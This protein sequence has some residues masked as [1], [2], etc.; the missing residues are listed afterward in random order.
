MSTAEWQ[1]WLDQSLS[2]RCALCE[3]DLIGLALCVHCRRSLNAVPR[4]CPVCA[5]P[6]QAF[7]AHPPH[8][9]LDSLH[10]PFVYA[11]NARVLIARLKFDRRRWLGQVLGQLLRRELTAQYD[12]CVPVPLYRRRLAQRGF[13]QALEIARGL[14][15]A[16]TGMRLA[17][18]V[19]R[20]RDTP[21]QALLSAADRRRNL[22]DCFELKA[23]VE[24]RSILVV[25]DVVTTG[26][27]LNAIAK[28]LRNHGAR[29]VTGIAFARAVGAHTINV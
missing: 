20:V 11:G 21:P 19:K 28:L 3:T 23:E 13:N 8:W 18:V 17:A 24:Q 7:C 6:M 16:V 14:A 9:G 25:D 22:T 2:G 4:P 5:L 27:T 15:P 26:S 12:L 1:D 29:R 10:A